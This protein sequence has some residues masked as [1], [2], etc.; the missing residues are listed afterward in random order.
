MAVMDEEELDPFIKQALIDRLE[1]WELV[2]LLNIDAEAIVELF[3][4][5]ILDK[6]EEVLEI[7]GITKLDDDGDE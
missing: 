1:G 5:Q 3:E 2:E 7:V 4:D 6:L